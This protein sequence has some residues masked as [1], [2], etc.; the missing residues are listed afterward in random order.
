[1]KRIELFIAVIMLSCMLTSLGSMLFLA[2]K[3]TEMMYCTIAFLL[4]A[5]CGILAVAAN[6]AKSS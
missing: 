1:M 5:L 2:T 4:S 3:S 6:S